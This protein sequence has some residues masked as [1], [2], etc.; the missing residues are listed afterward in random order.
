MEKPLI[1]ITNDDGIHAKGLRYLIELMREFG[2]VVVVAPDKA[3]SGMGHAV[4]TASPLRVKKILI[5]PDY[6]EYS[7]NGTPADTV[8]LGLKVVLKQKPDLIVSGINHGSN[9]GINILYSGTM[10]ATLEGAMSGIPSIGFSLLDHSHNADFSHSIPYIRKI[11]EHVLK[12]GLAPHTC[13]NVNIPSINSGEIRGIMVCRMG[14]GYWEEV[15]EER[16]DPH[17]RPYYW[18]AGSFQSLDHGTDTDEWALDNHYI[19]VVPIQLDLTAHNLIP[20]LK[21]LENHI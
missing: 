2:R 18:L 16:R 10:G 15:L 5:E 8:K 14:K 4:T 12:Q 3:Q 19:S 7:S 9:A 21:D 11:T 13:L 17:N 20:T 1:F 6:E